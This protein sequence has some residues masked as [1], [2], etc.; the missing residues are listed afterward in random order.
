MTQ[1]AILNCNRLTLIQTNRSNPG[2]QAINK[3]LH[4]T[5]NNDD[6][7]NMIEM[8]NADT[9][10]AE[11]MLK[12]LSFKFRCMNILNNSMLNILEEL[13]DSCVQVNLVYQ[14]FY[15]KKGIGF[16]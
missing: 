9:A 10:G 1:P 6:N 12:E 2:A 8:A 3:W 13:L 4:H 15:T 5:Q 7:I 16:F 11:H 14:C